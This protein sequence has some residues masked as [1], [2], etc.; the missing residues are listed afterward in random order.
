MA[1]SK[2]KS[3]A[4]SGG[5]A[6]SD[7]AERLEQLDRQ[8]VELANERAGIAVRLANGRTEQQL[9]AVDFAA[10]EAQVTTALA[11]SSGP[12]SAESLRAMLREVQSGCRALVKHIRV[13]FLGPRYSYSHQAAGSFF[14]TNVELI[15]VGTIAAVFGEI[16]RGHADFGLVPLE[17]STDGRVA[18]TL[19]MFTRFPIRICGEVPLR[20]HHNLLAKCPRSEIS[21]VYSKPQALSQ[22][23][24]WLAKQ[25]P[26]ARLV[27]ITSTAAAA[28]VAVDKPGA[29]AV[30][31][32][33]AATHYGLNIVA[34]NIEDKANNLTR[35]AVI[36]GADIPKRTGN[37]KTSL[38]FELPHRP[39]ALADAMVV[40]KKH[41]LNLT[42]I[43][44]FPSPA[45]PNE[46][47]FFA[48]FEGHQADD[49]PHRAIEA[50]RRRCVRLEVLGSYPR[51][52]IIE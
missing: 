36:G 52:T 45:A 32:I 23:R 14:G 19:D 44:S 48:E 2:S 5:G 33:Q 49:D 16:T 41:G 27:E 10:E 11:S 29:A 51:G 38:M 50:L 1:K 13:A 40:F 24:E 34:A 4:G 46:Y 15:P 43:E 3:R 37:D 25:L 26:A 6:D 21:E 31:S 18:D 7:L 28:Q 8:L 17:N 12:L 9:P 42:W 20:I 47:L 35:F 39:G 22:C 30:A